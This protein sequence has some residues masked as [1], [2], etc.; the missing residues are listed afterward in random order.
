MDPRESSLTS[1]HA[2]NIIAASSEQG[3]A[4][5]ADFASR[6]I[7]A[8]DKTLD[9][10]SQRID[11]VSKEIHSSAET[12]LSQIAEM[13]TR[14]QQAAKA[15]ETHFAGSICA[16][17]ARIEA[18]E[19]ARLEAVRRAE[20]AQANVLRESRRQDCYKEVWQFAPLTLR[21]KFVRELLPEG[22]FYHNVL[23]E[24][25]ALEELRLRGRDLETWL[26]NYPAMFADAVQ[27]LLSGVDEDAHEFDVLKAPP[28]DI[29][30]AQTLKAV[31]KTLEI[32]LQA[33]G[34]T[35]IAPSP[36]DA[37]MAEHEVIGEESSSHSEGS[38]ARLRRRGLRLQGRFVLP[39]QVI[40]SSASH[41]TM[42]EPVEVATNPIEDDF[43]NVSES[44]ALAIESPPP[45]DSPVL[46]K[47]T[48][49]GLE[50]ETIDTTPRQDHGEPILADAAN[51]ADTEGRERAEGGSDLPDWLRIL[52]QRTFGW[53][54]PAITSL[55][56]K[57][58]ALN[59]LPAQLMLEPPEAAGKLL[60]DALQPLLPLL[61]MR[62][63]DGIPG[64]PEEQ[65]KVLLDVREPLLAWLTERMRVL[66]IAPVRGEAF[67]PQTM[68]EVETRRTVHAHEDKTVA[69]L[70]RIGLSWRD[71][72]LIRAQVV[73]YAVEGGT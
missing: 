56:D 11:E 54:L 34:I 43:V 9:K 52:G 8:V 72:P 69:K 37:I 65:G 5:P 23:K 19:N 68:E 49:V 16:L 7:E 47:E 14:V 70:E 48:G 33:L 21:L 44:V 31:Q 20:E 17:A 66:P 2:D 24:A 32:D 42:T 60:N 26:T 67:D 30:A 6:M 41:T 58:F 50:T 28:V 38:I 63:A 46:P 40:R 71:S 51:R 12:L 39:A 35:W 4:V 62:Y 59:D 55:V 57:V 73:R 27:S 61:G 53:D 3:T 1:L 10:Q 45:M 29:I 36:G 64:I 15:A 25:A 13:E 18:A 22:H